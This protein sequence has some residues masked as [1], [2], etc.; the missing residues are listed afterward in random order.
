MAQLMFNTA[1][2][3]TTDNFAPLPAGTYNAVVVESNV[4]DTKAGTGTYAKMQLKVLDGEFAG[5]VIF[6]NITLTNPNPTAVEIGQKHMA[7]L[8]NAVGKATIQDTQELHNQPL[9][10]QVKVKKDAEWGDSN[11]VV[12]YKALQGA[13]PAPAAQG[14]AQAAPAPAATA[15]P[16]K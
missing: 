11:E 2:I 14:Q 12:T 15:T 5:R 10:V 9:Q 8:C 6:H 3:D 13:A 4:L 7:L 16:W 1:G